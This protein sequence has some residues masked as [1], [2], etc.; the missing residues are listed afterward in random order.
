MTYA[1]IYECILCVKRLWPASAS[2]GL[3]LLPCCAPRATSNTFAIPFSARCCPISCSPAVL[4]FLFA[5]RSQGGTSLD[6]TIANYKSVGVRERH[7]P[8]EK[9]G[10]VEWK[11]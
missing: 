3:A 10:F 5:G 1:G 4:S 11:G 7:F 9:C 8:C 6:I 2:S